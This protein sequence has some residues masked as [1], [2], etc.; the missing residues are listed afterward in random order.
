ML[1]EK[2]TKGH[3][4]LLETRE[5][6]GYGSFIVILM[7]KAWNSGCF[8]EAIVL[9][10][11]YP[12][13]PPTHTHRWLFPHRFFF[14]SDLS[15]L[16][17]KLEVEIKPFHFPSGVMKTLMLTGAELWRPLPIS[18]DSIELNYS[19]KLLNTMPW[20]IAHR[21]L[22]IAIKNLLFGSFSSPL[23][24]WL[25]KCYFWVFIC[26]GSKACYGVDLQRLWLHIHPLL[27]NTTQEKSVITAHECLNE[28]Y[29]WWATIRQKKL[30]E[31]MPNFMPSE[32]QWL[33]S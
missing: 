18:S 14:Y 23:V 5:L 22:C 9:N 21:N 25:T 24:S 3:L 29:N 12:S 19:K 11:Q 7:N 2:V 26:V 20:Q 28:L 32:W 31:N 6:Y 15:V 10:L 16:F 33:A 4:R 17:S 8:S 27:G 1:E 13:P 30:A